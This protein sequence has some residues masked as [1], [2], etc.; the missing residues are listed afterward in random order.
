MFE[1]LFLIRECRKIEKGRLV[2]TIIFSVIK[3]QG[4]TRAVTS[5]LTEMHLFEFIIRQKP[6][7]RN[8]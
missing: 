6:L 3:K 1:L 5:I 8:W 7:W 2:E 4:L